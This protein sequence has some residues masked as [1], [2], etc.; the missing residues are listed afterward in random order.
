M[1]LHGLRRKLLAFYKLMFEEKF[2]SKYD[3][4]KDKHENTD[5]VDAMHVFYKPRFRTVRI[6]LFNVE[7]FRYLLK[8]AHKKTVS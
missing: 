4:A 2:D 6:R 7:V 8:Y 5:A 1:L 3:E